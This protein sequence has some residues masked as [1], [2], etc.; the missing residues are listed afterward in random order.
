MNE[1]NDNIRLESLTQQLNRIKFNGLS[2]INVGD[3]LI[4]PV[5]NLI[6]KSRI[7]SCLP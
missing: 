2:D 6:G 3:C 5:E 7:V 4:N 1:I